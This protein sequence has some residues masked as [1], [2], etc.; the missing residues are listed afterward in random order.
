MLRFQWLKKPYTW[1]KTKTA[2][3]YSQHLFNALNML[4]GLRLTYSDVLGN[5]ELRALSM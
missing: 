5:R 1:Y 3:F 2:N 4:N